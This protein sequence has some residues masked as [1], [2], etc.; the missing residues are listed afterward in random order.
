MRPTNLSFRG[1]PFGDVRGGCDNPDYT[2]VVI[3]SGFHEK[4]VEPRGLPKSKGCDFLPHWQEGSYTFSL[5]RIQLRRR[6][7]V[8]QLRIGLSQYFF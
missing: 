2:A 5:Y 4:V 3:Q 1:H 6:I 8:H 7:G